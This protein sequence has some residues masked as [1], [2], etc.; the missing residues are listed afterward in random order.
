VSKRW[1][2]FLDSMDRAEEQALLCPRNPDDIASSDS[3]PI[4]RLATIQLHLIWRALGL[5]SF[6]DSEWLRVGGTGDRASSEAH[7]RRGDSAVRIAAQ[8]SSRGS[9]TLSHTLTCASRVRQWNT[10]VY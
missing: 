4:A 3:T 7:D 10:W 8:H 2:V 5:P 1:T 9:Y 6:K